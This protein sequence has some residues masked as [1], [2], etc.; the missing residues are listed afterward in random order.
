MNINELIT[1]SV[2]EDIKKKL[3]SFLYEL[4]SLEA[5]LWGI[6]LKETLNQIEDIVEDT[7]HLIYLLSRSNNLS[8]EKILEIKELNEIKKELK[9]LK[10]DFNYLK[11]KIEKNNKLKKLISEFSIKMLNETNYNK[12]KEIFLL[13]KYLYLVLEKQEEDLNEITDRISKLKISGKIDNLS[14]ER[15]IYNL[16]LLREVL[17]DPLDLNK[18]FEEE[19]RC[20]SVVSNIIHKI[21]KL[22][23]EIN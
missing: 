9:I 14:K 19:R 4:K 21:I 10:K 22:V 23:K 6:N 18:E 1:L 12:F 16:K 8:Y 11:Q 13:E 5:R 2:D 15:L 7:N 17:S 3:L 20:Y